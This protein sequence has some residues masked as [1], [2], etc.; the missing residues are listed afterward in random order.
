MSQQASELWH[1]HK[2]VLWCKLVIFFTRC[3]RFQ[4]SH[5]ITTCGVCK[6]LSYIALSYTAGTGIF[7]FLWFL[8]V[9]STVLIRYLSRVF[10]KNPSLLTGSIIIGIVVVFGAIDPQKHL[11]IVVFIPVERQDPRAPTLRI[12]TEETWHAGHQLGERGRTPSLEQGGHCL[13]ELL[14]ALLL[15]HL[16]KTERP[17]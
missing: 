13:H 3:F 14:R 17:S 15:H 2:Y 16:R 1:F 7:L 10:F 12:S 6:T 5:T 8:S 9:T 4:K 11:I